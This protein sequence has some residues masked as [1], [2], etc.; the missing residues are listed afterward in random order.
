MQ[1]LSLY[2]APS[3]GHP[4]FQ[5][6]NGRS[7][8]AQKTYHPPA[9][10]AFVRYPDRALWQSRSPPAPRISEIIFL[11]S[12]SVYLPATHSAAAS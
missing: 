12:L 1:A 5:A 9:S 10:A 6:N 3:P 7:H 11:L 2:P 8:A 4:A